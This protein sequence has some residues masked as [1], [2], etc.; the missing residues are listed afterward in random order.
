MMII[1][2]FIQNVM[3]INIF[4]IICSI[5]DVFEE[6]MLADRFNILNTFVHFILTRETLFSNKKKR[7]QTY[8]PDS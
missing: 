7:L 3:D 5:S 1:I 8:L 6:V 4:L 2:S